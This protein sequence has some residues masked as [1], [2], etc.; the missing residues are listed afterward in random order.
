MSAR[1]DGDTV[2][3]TELELVGG[4]PL[5]A[6]AS[7]WPAGTPAIVA[8]LE[9]CNPGGSVKDRPAAHMVAAAERAGRLRPGGT[10]VAPTSG[11]TGVG[12]AMLAAR[13]GYRC[14]FTCPDKVSDERLQ[15]LRAFGAEVVVCPAA[16]APDDPRSY[17][18]VAT[19]LA[20][21]LPGA[22]E[23]DQ[24]QDPYNAEAHYLSTGPEIWRQTDGQLTHFVA[25]VGTGGTIC[26][27]GRYLKEVS[28]GR[29]RVI[30]ADPDGSVFSGGPGR[31]HLLEGVGQPSLPASYD[32]AVADE[33]IAVPD[34][35]SLL[36]ARRLAREEGLLA[37]ASSG[38]AVAA[39]LALAQRPGTSGLIVV[40]LPDSGRGYL[41]RLHDDRWM[42][43][44]GLLT[45]GGAGP[46]LAD[47]PDG[48][49]LPGLPTPTT[50]VHAVLAALAAADLP[51]VPVVAGPGRHRFGEIVG[52]VTAEAARAARDAGL[53]AR[54][55]AEAGCVGPALPYLGIGEPVAR[56]AGEL[57]AAGPDCVV[58]LRDGV[59]AAVLSGRRIRAFLGPTGERRTTRQ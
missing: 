11:N 21:T 9:Y 14:V 24:Y 44:M 58:V 34:R 35:D 50:A 39:A 32:P 6:L 45:P 4:T 56:A 36:T 20:A 30:G 52:A 41:G 48:P 38:L 42:A 54:P 51:A 19:R 2:A 29:V 3:A 57:A 16:V 37:G 22:V 46:T 47:L 7:L 43:R 18:G 33:V 5:V 59:I 15:A 55:I 1:P 17:R 31:P 23:L 26:G 8:K 49:D 27:A 13:R 28:G 53:G 40:V 25:S 12:L 10:I